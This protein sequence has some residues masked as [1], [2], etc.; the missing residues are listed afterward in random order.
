MAILKSIFSLFKATFDE[1]NE[2]RA[3]RLAAALSYYT[4]FSIAPFLIVVIAI[5]SLVAT[6]D[7][8]RGSLD[9]QIQG[10]VGRE[11]ADMIQ[12]L[13]QNT[14]K[15]SEN[16]LATIIGV[17]TLLLGAGGVFGQLQDALNTVWGVKPRPG[18]S[19]LVTIK[20][21]FLSFTM[22]L[23][24]GFMLLV[25]LLLSSFLSSVHTFFLGLLPSAEFLLQI[26]NFVI[27][28]G[29]ITLLFALMYKILPDVEIQWRDVGVG[30]A[31]TSLLFVIGK[32]ALGLY[33]G[34]SGVLSTYGAAGSLIIILL[35]IFYSAQILL[36]GAEFTQVYA[37]KYGS[38]ITPS[39][40]A[41]A[42]TAEA[43]AQEGLEPITDKATDPAA[44][45]TPAPLPTAVPAAVPMAAVPA[46]TVAT[47]K[48]GKISA[49]PPMPEVVIPPSDVPQPTQPDKSSPAIDAP[50][51]VALTV[52]GGVA[53]FLI[54]IFARLRQEK[55]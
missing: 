53:G 13:I 51:S 43:R 34:N 33:L 19:F 2:D 21:R 24:V 3:P 54:G 15:P 23:G 9:E 27:S 42:I 18:R 29:V 17:V 1:W 31:V 4:I 44:G 37:Q 6:P 28:F 30:A 41:V 55:K 45:A 46:A 40:N 52:A 48:N 35:W 25:S 26:V 16:I 49:I 22:V 5:A 12:E 14:N 39:P 32:T 47:A 7:A 38:R 8:V 11:G 10:L 36:F 50:A 20:D